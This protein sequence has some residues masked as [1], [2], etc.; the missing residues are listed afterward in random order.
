MVSN[1]IEDMAEHAQKIK[2]YFF[3]KTDVPFL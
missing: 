1:F 3:M 2:D